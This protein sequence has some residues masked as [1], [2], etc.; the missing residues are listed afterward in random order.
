MIR[1]NKYLATAGVGSRRTCDGYISA[2]RIR[3]NGQLVQKLGTRIDETADKVYFDGRPVTVNDNMVYIM[4][5]KPAGIITTASDEFDRPTVLDLIPVEERIFPVGRL[6]QDTTGLLLLTNDGALANELIHPRYKIPKTYHA[7]I[8]KKIHPKDIYHFEHGLMLDDKMTAPCTLAE[9]RIIDNCSFVQIIIAEGRNRQI[10]R[11][12]ELLG[13]QVETLERIAF[14]PLQLGGL[15]EK[16]WR[17]LTVAE[18][19]RLR[20]LQQQ[21]P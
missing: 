11:M 1:L 12:L 2:G 18:L 4:L 7:L 16:E 6:D 13:Y 17:Y 20:Q 21:I 19:E 15:K 8:D 3:V 5:N 10:R 14:G 9:I